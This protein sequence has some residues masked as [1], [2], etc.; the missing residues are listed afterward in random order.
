MDNQEEGLPQYA[1]GAM[2]VMPL[3]ELVNDIYDIIRQRPS[4]QT[5]ATYKWMKK[6]NEF[7]DL[8]KYTKPPETAVKPTDNKYL[9]LVRKGVAQDITNHMKDS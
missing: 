6:I 1:F 7:F 4:L 5:Q 8:H 9:D 2:D 3:V